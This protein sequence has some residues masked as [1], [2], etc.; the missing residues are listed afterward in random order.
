MKKLRV[1]V[2]GNGNEG[3]SLCS[4]FIN[5]PSIEIKGFTNTSGTHSEIT[6][7]KRLGVSIF[8][9]VEE[10]ISIDGLEIIFET[11]GNPD[12]SQKLRDLKKAN[13]QIVESSY[14]HL[15]K[16]LK[17][18]HFTIEASLLSLI[19]SVDEGVQIVD[20][21]GNILQ[22]N[23]TFVTL[24]GFSYQNLIGNNVFDL[25][26]ESPTAKALNQ[27]KPLSGDGYCFKGSSIEL[28]F[29]VTPLINENIIYGSVAVYK[30]LTDVKKLMKE[31]KRSRAII[32]DIYERLAQREKL[33][34]L[35]DSDVIPIDHMEQVLLK[36]ALTKYGYTVEGKKL[37]ASALNISLATLYNKLKKYQIS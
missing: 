36:Q 31:L 1:A 16:V 7:L 26:P 3:A 19:Q 12:V 11:S 25:M 35:T 4:M 14:L 20:K 37:A 29:K 17:N 10:L 28:S 23:D 33:P 32:E 27:A 34:E 22:V 8:Q 18:Q 2:I 30:E 13:I 5:N 15:I 6:N 9:T 24:S 21:N